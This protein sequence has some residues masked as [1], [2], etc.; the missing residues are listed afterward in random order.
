[1]QAALPTN[2]TVVAGTAT[3]GV[4]GT[5]VYQA[6]SPN[7][8]GT[9]AL[10]ITINI[11]SGAGATIGTGS[12]SQTGPN[13]GSWGY[14][15]TAD[16]NA[17]IAGIQSALRTALGNA[18]LTITGAATIAYGVNNTYTING[19][20][21]PLANMGLNN[22]LQIGST[23]GSTGLINWAR[24][25]NTQ[26][27]TATQAGS[28]LAITIPG[29][30]TTVTPIPAF[31]AS[32]TT[33]PGTGF[34]NG[35]ITSSGAFANGTTVY[36]TLTSATSISGLPTSNIVL[37]TGGAML[38]GG[39]GSTYSITHVTNIGSTT[40]VLQNGTDTILSKNISST[41]ASRT[42]SVNS[43]L[44]YTGTLNINPGT[45]VYNVFLSDNNITGGLT[46]N[47]T[48]STGSVE[49][50]SSGNFG[51]TITAGTGVTVVSVSAIV[52]GGV[53][54]TVTTA[55]QVRAIF[56]NATGTAYVTNLNPVITVGVGTVTI[57]ITAVPAT[58]YRVVVWIDNCYPVGGGATLSIDTANISLTATSIPN[59]I[60]NFS[61]AITSSDIDIYS[62]SFVTYASASGLQTVTLN[63]PDANF[64]V[65][66]TIPGSSTL[67]YGQPTSGLWRQIVWRALAQSASSG[68]TSNIAFQ[69]ALALGTLP[70]Q[71][72]QWNASGYT[73]QNGVSAA[74][75]T[76][77]MTVQKGVSNNLTQILV[78]SFVDD[79]A[80]LKV[81]AFPLY[82]FATSTTDDGRVVTHQL[83]P[84]QAVS[85][86]PA[87]QNAVASYA[88]DG[89]VGTAAVP[90]PLS[91]VARGVENAQLLI[92]QT[93][94]IP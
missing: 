41:D 64:I 91:K 16:Q 33:P 52:I 8:S 24:P 11:L 90:G 10:V 69:N 23:G 19:N 55:A 94:A 65:N 31:T 70:S 77:Q 28:T 9:T 54:S 12:F 62:R 35:F 82:Q 6:G 1:M 3:G 13:A 61:S 26:S 84:A 47:R 29:V 39:A 63:T 4:T 51:G 78:N 88:V 58:Q 81:L 71:F 67:L 2:S 75:P 25:I 7:A 40:L 56:M 45:F 42:L 15:S 85:L 59:S 72:I 43:M 34:S 20:P 27:V 83:N 79:T 73:V 32:G 21:L 57:G 49:V 5:I 86:S 48:G 92:P 18:T 53:P 87:D 37:T 76:I 93:I 17:I 68:G 14:N 74:S 80:G 89:I 60:I 30:A 46:I 36:Q 22:N 44:G 38:S 50:I 66:A